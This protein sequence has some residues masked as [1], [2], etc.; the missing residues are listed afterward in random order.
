LGKEGKTVD[1][2]TTTKRAL[3]VHGAV[4]SLKLETIRTETGYT[5][6]ATQKI[7][8]ECLRELGADLTE[9]NRVVVATMARGLQR[10]P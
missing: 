4:N 8:E 5:C 3:C 6:K 1:D 2:L 9:N 10:F 7:C